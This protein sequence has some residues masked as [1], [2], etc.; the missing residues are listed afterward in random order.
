MW[1]LQG[2]VERPF[3]YIQEHL[4]RGLHVES[5]S[6]FEKRL[7]NFTKEYNRRL[8]STLK[9]SPEERFL[10]EKERLRDIPSVEPRVLWNREHRKVTNDGY[11]WWKG[12]LYPVPMS[13]CLRDVMIEDVFGRLIRVYD[14]NG[15]LIAEHQRDI[16]GRK[17]RPVHPEHEAMNK[18]FN[19]KRKRIRSALV[20]KFISLFGEIG[21]R[22]IKGLKDNTGPNLYWHLEQILCCCDVYEVHVVRR[23]IEEC[24]E[25]GSYH[26]NS[27][28]RV[29]SSSPL[30]GSFRDVSF[31]G[32][33]FTTGRDIT[34]P[35]SAYC[36]LKEVGHE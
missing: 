28:I 21:T 34:R 32:L 24:I 15:K 10:R 1:Q 7:R 26:K 17:T 6:E 36:V 5:L 30:K 12:N 27:I 18:G 20:E 16:S 23:A 31:K 35:L 14:I 8:H 9:E 4:L 25:I 29:L 22:Y 19:D 2:K 3:Y 33:R 11:I 13:Y